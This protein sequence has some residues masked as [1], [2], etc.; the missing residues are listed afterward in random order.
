[1]HSLNLAVEGLQSQ[2]ELLTLRFEQ[3]REALATAEERLRQASERLETAKDPGQAG[4][5]RRGYELVALRARAASV[6]LQA[7][8]LSIRRVEE[9][10]DGTKARLVF[11]QRQLDAVS[12][13]VLFSEADLAQVRTRL[14]KERLRFEEQLEQSLVERQRQSQIVQRAEQRLD[15]LRN[16]QAVGKDSAEE[17]PA[18]SRSKA[19]VELAQA[20]MDNLVSQ[21]DLWQQL[22]NIVEGERQLWENRFVIAHTS[23]PGKA[24]EAYERF[25]RLFDNFRA[26]RDYLRQQAGMISGQISEVE[27]RMRHSQALLRATL[28]DLIRTLHEREQAYTRA[29]HRMDE[30]VRF[31][32][33][34]RDEFKEQQKELPL[35]DRFE[36]WLTRIG[37]LI[38]D[39]W[40]YE[41]FSAEDTIEVDG[42]TMTGHRSVTVG[43]TLTA[44][45]IFLIGY[46][47]CVYLARAISRLAVTRFGTGADVANLVRQWKSSV[48]HHVLD[49]AELLVGEDPIDDFC[50]SRRSLCDRGR[51]RRADTL[52][53][54]DQW[55]SVIDRTA[56]A[57]RR[58]YRG[59]QC[60]RSGDFDRSSFFHH[61]RRQGNGDADTEQQFPRT[62]PHELDL[63]EPC[64]AVSL[65]SGLHTVRPLNRS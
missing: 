12:P 58:P 63:L 31:M 39:A 46:V 13:H 3:A 61:Q 17:P 32:E 15:L 47:V 10:L 20:R 6:L 60:S 11:E 1:M 8:Q 50:V 35:F 57:G 25:T 34:W 48:A 51:I 42:K 36:E 28:Q 54:H 4:R 33:R 52:E 2:R 49:R 16:K 43:K 27:N 9:E 53:K 7:A 18:L 40:R 65:E 19:V 62:G 29:L 45:A 5:E 21:S 56:D 41:L 26:S 55:D 22:V 44:L 59:R 24:H 37:S 64:R 38:K 23:E 30:A 14:E